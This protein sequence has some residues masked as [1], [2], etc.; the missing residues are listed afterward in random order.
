MLARFREAFG[1]GGDVL[2]PDG[3]VLVLFVG[4]GTVPKIARISGW[5][6]WTK[7]RSEL[8]AINRSKDCGGHVLFGFE[9]EIGDGS[10]RTQPRWAVRITE[11]RRV[12]TR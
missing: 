7:V 4:S 5:A 3:A 11:G 10:M 9:A 1:A 12:S 8:I 2:V 6:S